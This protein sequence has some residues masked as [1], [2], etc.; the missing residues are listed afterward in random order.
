MKLIRS[1]FVSLTL[2]LL[3]AMSSTVFSQTDQ[4]T[5]G[6]VRKV[7]K[8]NSKVTIKHE[9]IKSL[10]MPPMTMVF[11]VKNKSLLDKIQVGEAVRFIVIQEG[12][13]LVVTDLK[14]AQ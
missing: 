4:M 6:V 12:G 3:A 14:P 1:I 2:I 10:D 11:V 7:D 8:E 9:E 5:D 13:K